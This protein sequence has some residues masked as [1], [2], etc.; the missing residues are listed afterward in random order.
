LSEKKFA[1][2]IGDWCYGQE[3]PDS[4]AETR[5]TLVAYEKAHTNKKLSAA[6]ITNLK[7]AEKETVAILM[8]YN[9]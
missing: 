6:E 3:N 4:C 2:I 9:D 5:V 1:V 8:V 7:P